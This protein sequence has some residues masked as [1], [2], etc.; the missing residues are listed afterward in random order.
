MTWKEI[1]FDSFVADR[2]AI[3]VEDI[4]NVNTRR[5]MF[6][7]NTEIGLVTGYVFINTDGIRYLQIYSSK[8]ENFYEI[9]EASVNLFSVSTSSTGFKTQSYLNNLLANQQYILRKLL[10][11]SGI[12][13]DLERKGFD[14][15]VYRR[16]IKEL[17]V[18]LQE[19]NDQVKLATEE[20][21]LQK[22]Y[23]ANL[24]MYVPY[25]DKIVNDQR[26]S[27]IGAIPVAIFITG[28][29]ISAIVATYYVVRSSIAIRAAEEASKHHVVI[30]DE[31]NELL[32]KVDPQTRQKIIADL[33]A[34]V[35]EAA[36]KAYLSSQSVGWLDTVKTIAI[37]GGIAFVAFKWV[38]PAFTKK[39]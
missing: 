15:T 16:Q 17:F 1:T 31:L 30:S 27:G 2:L 26:I 18:A 21:S 12:V 9:E 32:M 35:G 14:C 33:D 19:R 13:A 5:I 25:L 3:A 24:S 37:W 39:S 22:G 23:D 38:L 34:Q 4:Y 11:C 29:V 7:S 28:I 6:T 10:I 36:R 20:S 8:G